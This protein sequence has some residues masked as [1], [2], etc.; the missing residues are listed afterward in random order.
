MPGGGGTQTLPRAVGE[1]RA[2]E[3]ILTG[4]PFSAEEA[5]K[6]GV[7][8]RLCEPRDLLPEALRTAEQIAASTPDVVRKTKAALKELR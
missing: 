5:L 8:N 4:L 7:V 1:R 2:K 6:W 3:I